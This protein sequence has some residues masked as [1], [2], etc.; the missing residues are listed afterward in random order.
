DPGDRLVAGDW[1]SNGQFTPA[2]YRGSNTTMYFRYSNTQGVADHQWSGG[3]SSWIPV[4]GA[5]GF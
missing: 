4:S 1:N 2:L 3:Q 5:T